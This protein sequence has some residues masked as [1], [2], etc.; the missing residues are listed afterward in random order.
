M[1]KDGQDFV[2]SATDLA[3]FLACRHRTA[4]EMLAAAGLRKRP[5]SDD[6]LLELLF[7]RGLEHEKA[8]VDQLRNDGLDILDLSGMQGDELLA[9]TEKGLRDGRD[10]IVQ[11]ALREGQWY[12]KPDILRRVAA[13]SALGPWSYEVMDTKLARETRAGTVLQLSLYSEML[14]SLQKLEPEYFYVV[15]PDPEQPV[16]RY[17]VNDYAAYVRLTRARLAATA[18]QSAEDVAAANYPE[19]VDHCQICA[20]ARDCREKRCEDDHLSLVAGITRTQRRELESRG[21]STTTELARLALPIPFKP[22][23]GSIESYERVREQARLQVESRDTQRPLH[24]LL[25]IVPKEGLCR[26]PAPTPGDIFL[27]LEGG[28]IVVEGGREYLFGLVSR[29]ENGAV[30]YE[31]YWAVDDRSERAAFEAVIDR[32]VS[33]IE[34][35]P[36]MHVYHYSP[37]EPAAFKRLMGRYATHESELDAMLRAGRFVDL[38]GVVREVLRAGIESYSIKKLEALYSFEREVPLENAGRALRT[39]EYALAIGEANSLPADVRKTVEDYNRDDCVST[40]RLYDW[41]ET[42]RD[43]AIEDGA[44][45][46]RPGLD[47][48]EPSPELKERQLRT[49]ALR[50]RLLADMDGIPAMHT[51][52]HARWLFAYLLDFHPRESKAGWWKYYE[53]C[54]S[55]DDDL[56]DEPEAVA[57]LEYL[58]RVEIKVNKKT[59]KPTGSVVDRYSFP[60]QEMEIRR[61]GQLK[62]RDGTGFGKVVAVDRD[63]RTIDVSKGTKTADLHPVAVFEHTYVST[64]TLEDAIAAIG[65]SVAASTQIDG[66][67]G[68][69]KALL[70]RE[71][72]RLKCGE[73]RQPDDMDTSGF[74]VKVV[75]CL[76][77]TVLPIQGPPGS[78][79]TYTGARM[80]LALVEQR[81]RVGVTGPSHKAIVNL[82]KETIDAAAEAGKTVRVAHRCDADD[83]DLPRSITRLKDSD[84]APQVLAEREFDVVGGTPWLWAREDMVSAVDVLFVDE[85]GQVSLA[86]AIAVSRSASSMVLLGDP[87]QLE[88]PL[89]GSHPDGVDASALHHVIGEHGTIPNDKGI[90]LAETWRLSPAICAFTS[91]LFYESRLKS[92]PKLERQVLTGVDGFEGSGLWYVDVEHEGRTSAS[93]EEASVVADLVAQLTARGSSWISADGETVQLRLE[94]VLVVA[95]FNAQ[96]SRLADRL[97]PGARVGTVDKFQGQAAPVVIYSMATSR[98]EDAPRGL[99]FLYSLNRLNVATSRAKCAAIVVA[100]RRLY[101]VEC[102]S[103]SQMVLA[104]ALCRFR[105]IG[106][107]A[108]DATR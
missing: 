66:A 100:N 37:Y 44:E 98:P 49:E 74:A 36:E 1:R 27:D 67:N 5:Y 31:S 13:P 4:L 105:E 59:K 68:I 29:G 51:P 104:N 77:S 101:G 78:G 56:L 17:R 91:E 20:W 71:A 108:R 41:L 81:K 60:P 46:P 75:S 89:Q 8:Y 97:P 96:V 52:E 2:L 80:I 92:K 79:K 65:E 53:L 93:D 11:G 22:S 26:L 16:K 48:A 99:A 45:I 23:R 107:A 42:L 62:T 50:A 35:Y 102:R 32:I 34:K 72:P 40:V 38:Y 25:E 85:A 43:K 70:A 83:V 86:N 7:K 15:T 63:A 18:K 61:G 87:Q 82:L 58:A 54:E 33:A 6:P 103:P 64:E 106:K 88:Q 24:E 90:F 12:G 95:P 14:A 21:T 73:F 76:D 10:V 69:A 28:N 94:D 30:E 57:G 55:T 39:F 84:E 19:P 9:A 3:N 47:E